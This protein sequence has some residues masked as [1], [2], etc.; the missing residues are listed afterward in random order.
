[1]LDRGLD[2]LQRR[3]ADLVLDG[4][5][6]SRISSYLEVSKV[7]LCKWKKLPAWKEYLAEQT[8]EGLEARSHR[9]RRVCDLALET[10]ESALVD[11]EIVPLKR[12][13]L[14]IKWLTLIRESVT[15][16]AAAPAPTE[17][18]V[19]NQDVIRQIREKVYG[20]YEADSKLPNTPVETSD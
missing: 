4:W 11:P 17:G 19:L 16:A 5:P 9:V 2:D 12:A 14:A 1:M 3:A 13:E 15:Q 10:I 8:G 6:L 20:I 18:R 7:S